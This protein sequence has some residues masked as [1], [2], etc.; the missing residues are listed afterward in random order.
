MLEAKPSRKLLTMV[1]DMFGLCDLQVLSLLEAWYSMNICKIRPANDASRLPLLRFL[2]IKF[3]DFRE[4]VLAEP[5]EFD[6]LSD[7]LI[8]KSSD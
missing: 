3:E 5:R 1:L 6:L 2:R 7:P 4:E 8:T